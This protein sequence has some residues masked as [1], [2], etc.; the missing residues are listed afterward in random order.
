MGP[1]SAHGRCAR[2]PTAGRHLELDVVPRRPI[3]VSRAELDRLTVAA[4]ARVVAP[5]VAE[6]DA[7]DERHVVLGSGPPQQHELLVMAP[8]APHPFVEHELSASLVHRF[9]QMEVLLLAEV[10][11][12]RVRAP[13]QAAHV[14]A[15]RR[16][17]G[18]DPGHFGARAGEELVGVAA[19]VGEVDP[20]APLERAEGGVEPC[21]VLGAVN[22]DAHVVAV[23]VGR[24]RAI[25]AA[26]DLRGR[27]PALLDRQEPCLC[28][29]A[30]LPTHDRCHRPVLRA[31]W[32][33]RRLGM[34]QL[35]ARRTTPI[36]AGPSCARRFDRTDRPA[37]TPC[38]WHTSVTV[39][40]PT[41]TSRLRQATPGSPST[42]NP[43]APCTPRPPCSCRASPPVRLADL[44]VD[45]R[46]RRITHHL[47][48]HGRVHSAH[49]LR[50]DDH[51]GIRRQLEGRLDLLVLQRLP[52]PDL[53]AE[54]RLVHG[55][56]G[57]HASRR[58]TGKGDTPN[59]PLVNR[60]PWA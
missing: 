52:V 31:P 44:E 54:Q 5:P 27:V 43:R 49:A 20:L 45:E 1:P 12:V 11:P 26:V 57:H 46:P 23:A 55:L 48:V 13:H 28:T 60:R 18:Q 38:A 40:E 10:R 47:F 36:D 15:S 9:D 7:A 24:R 32:R 14:H 17:P 56:A 30:L 59:E 42:V 39:F 41:S 58:R 3:P 19:P 53:Q 4:V 51:T 6:V 33:S 50:A 22:E 34:P 25:A 35:S 29:H 8:A 2:S 16:Q 37:P 21:V